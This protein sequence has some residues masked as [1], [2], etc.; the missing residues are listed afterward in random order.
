MLIVKTN[1]PATEKDPEK[2]RN[3]V[4]LV[5]REVVADVGCAAVGD[6]NYETSVSTQSFR[7]Y[8]DFPPRA[9]AAL[10]KTVEGGTVIESEAI[11]GFHFDY[12]SARK[13]KCV[14]TDNA[15]YDEFPGNLNSNRAQFSFD[16][17]VVASGSY[18]VARL[19][20]WVP[21]SPFE[22]A[23][24]HRVLVRKYTTR[25]GLACVRFKVPLQSTD[26]TFQVNDLESRVSESS[27]SRKEQVGQK[28]PA[29]N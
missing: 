27:N 16:R 4:K 5:R 8:H 6:P 26:Y 22:G 13:R 29:G 2:L 28:W 21:V 7:D 15:E 1:R 19:F 11:K 9:T 14:R 25:A 12:R 20:F 23:A 3:K 18:S 24:E 17:T 10:R